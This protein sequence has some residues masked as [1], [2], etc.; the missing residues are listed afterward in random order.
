MGLNE[1]KNPWTDAHGLVKPLWN[2]EL[3][4]VVADCLNRAAFL[5]FLAARFFFG[6]FRLLE[7][8]AEATVFIALEIVRRGFA[9]QIAI[10]ALVVYVIFS[11]N[12]FR[13]FICNIS[14]KVTFS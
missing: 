14:H 13:I 1:K 11:R 2:R 3:L 5:G 7:D 10:N 4:P 12:I 6:G 9:A 8:I